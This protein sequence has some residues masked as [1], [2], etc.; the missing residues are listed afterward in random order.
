M[1]EAAGSHVFPAVVQQGNGGCSQHRSV[2]TRV[3][4]H[5]LSQL[6]AEC[7][8]SIISICFI[9]EMNGEINTKN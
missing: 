8:K 7:W 5:C 4:R 6:A 2:V 1:T 3:G 9:N